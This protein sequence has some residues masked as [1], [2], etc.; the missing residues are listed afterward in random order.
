M[1][2][3]QLLAGIGVEKSR[4]HV[5]GHVRAGV[6]QQGTVDLLGEAGSAA[7]LHAKGLLHSG[8]SLVSMS[9]GVQFDDT[10]LGSGKAQAAAKFEGRPKMSIRVL[11]PLDVRR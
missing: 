6:L 2:L 1:L 10:G 11:S 5:L 8:I 3:G 9:G 4:E 7:R